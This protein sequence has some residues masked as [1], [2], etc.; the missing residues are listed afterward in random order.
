MSVFKGD[1][2]K[3]FEEALNTIFYK[4]GSYLETFN[5]NRHYDGQAHT[6]QG[7]RGKQEVSG[8]TMRDIH[9]A[10]IRGFFRASC[11]DSED[12]PETVYDLD[13][14]KMDPVAVI[15]NMTC[16]V[17]KMMGIYPNV[18]SLK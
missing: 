11:L 15:Q 9:D 12:Y 4:A 5:R 1:E 14:S 18:S 7:E 6:N 8:V 10:C 13:L 3:E 17:E 16:E 2:R